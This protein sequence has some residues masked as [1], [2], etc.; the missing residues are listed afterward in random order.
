MTAHHACPL[1]L[2]P[3]AETVL[4]QDPALRVILAQEPDYPAFCRAIWHTHVREM[5]ELDRAHQ[6]HLMR[7]VFTT[8]Q[9]LR[10]LLHPDKINLASL[11]NVVPHLHWHIIP[12]FTDDRHF[13]KPIW[14]EAMRKAGEYRI[15][16]LDIDRLRQ[17]LA[18]HMT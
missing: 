8:E 17:F 6:Q 3:Q 12:R 11:G 14:G 2:P 16:S 7:A 13:P 15:A 4:W 1:C 10:E 5:S 18:T 9:A